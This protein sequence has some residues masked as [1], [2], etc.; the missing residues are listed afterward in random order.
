M[1]LYAFLATIVLA[2]DQLKARVEMSSA[3]ELPLGEFISHYHSSRK[4]RTVHYS[5]SSNFSA[6]TVISGTLALAQW[7]GQ[8]TP[9]SVMKLLN[10]N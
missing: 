10:F 1:G 7:A 9:V 2:E 4:T 5:P 3:E 6:T 8:P